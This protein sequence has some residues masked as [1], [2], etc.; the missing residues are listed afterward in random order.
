MFWNKL[1]KLNDTT[2]D[3]NYEIIDKNDVRLQ[4][5]SWYLSKY[6][7]KHNEIN[8]F[9]KL[10]YNSQIGDYPYKEKTED[11]ETFLQSFLDLHNDNSY[12]NIINII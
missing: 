5:I 8:K 2:Q 9:L 11:L 12:D 4:T 7:K 10:Y 1:F 6:F 3:D